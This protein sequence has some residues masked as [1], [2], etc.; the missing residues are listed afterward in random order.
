MSDNP[1]SDRQ[2]QAAHL[3][4]RAG[5]G[6]TAA[7][8]AQV[9]SLSHNQ[10][11][12]NLLNLSDLGAA[13]HLDPNKATDPKQVSFNDLGYWWLLTMAYTRQPLQEKMTLFWHGLF[14]S[15]YSKV[16]VPLL[17]VNQNEMFR[18]NA[19]GNFR[20]LVKKVA[21]DPAMLDYLDGE[22]NRKSSPNENW[23]REMMELFT[24]GIGNYSEQDVREAARAFTGWTFRGTEFVFQANQHDSGAKTFMGQT[25]N[26]DGDDI[27][28]II[29][30][31]RLTAQRIA[32][33]L[34]T[35]LAYPNPDSGLVGRLTDVFFNSN[36]DTKQLVRAILT[37]PEFLSMTAYRALV[38]SPV[39]YMVGMLKGLGISSFEPYLNYLPREMGQTLFNP[40]NV[41]GWMGGPAW[42][43][44]ASFF[45][46][47]NSADLF[48]VN[49]NPMLP[50]AY[51]PYNLLAGGVQ[52]ATSAQAMVD[53]LVQHLLDGQTAPQV[54]TA[55]SN[56]LSSGTNPTATDFVAA[57]NG[58]PAGRA[59]DMRVRGTLHL[60]MSSP[61]YILN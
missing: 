34:W 7:E 46:R 8:I 43:G 16:R 60:I 51:S 48:A 41:G 36:Y 52:S 29:L 3:L 32:T 5:F 21:R 30:S 20:D 15:A 18:A 27:I 31:N 2:V 1:L 35:F 28:N 13:F 38:K 24:I 33:R 58:N 56:Y 53:G 22:L 23:A 45:D 10:A 6:G 55:L 39:E 50:L 40:P 47:I 11:V 49:R 37:A 57:A 26:F 42:I 61:D 59:L 12:E 44:S 9:A 4:R 14:T 25:G 17:L 54:R 19:L